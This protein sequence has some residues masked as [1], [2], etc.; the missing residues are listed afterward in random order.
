MHSEYKLCFGGQG[1]L[2]KCDEGLLELAHNAHFQPKHF[3]KYAQLKMVYSALLKLLHTEICA[4]LN[5]LKYHV[6][7]HAF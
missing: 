5:D 3:E 2:R 1:I 4:H 6:S 7:Y